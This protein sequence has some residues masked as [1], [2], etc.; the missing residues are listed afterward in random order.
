MSKAAADGNAGTGKNSILPK[1]SFFTVGPHMLWR[2]KQSRFCTDCKINQLLQRRK[3]IFLTD[4]A[5]ARRSRTENP[6]FLWPHRNLK[7]CPAGYFTPVIGLKCCNYRKPAIFVLTVP[8]SRRPAGIL[9]FMPAR[10]KT[11]RPVV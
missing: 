5:T 10:P 9:F 3:T 6:F 7:A 2:R 11:L 1:T 4:K 8:L